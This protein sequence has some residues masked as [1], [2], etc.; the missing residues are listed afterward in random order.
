MKDSELYMSKEKTHLQHKVF[1]PLV[2]SEFE[3]GIFLKTIVETNNSKVLLVSSLFNLKLYKHEVL[4][5]L[6]V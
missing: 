5:F 3:V 2:V 6:L 4:F 1:N